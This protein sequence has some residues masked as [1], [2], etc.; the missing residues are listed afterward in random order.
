MRPGNDLVGL[1]RYVDTDGFL[2]ARLSSEAEP[3]AGAPPAML[4]E[5]EDESAAYDQPVYGDV[6][7]A[8]GIPAP[9]HPKSSL[10]HHSQGARRICFVFDPS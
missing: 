5:L 3:L 4:G 8:P 7:F 6:F 1:E 2:V 10:H 9:S